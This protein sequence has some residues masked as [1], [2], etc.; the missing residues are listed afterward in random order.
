MGVIVVNIWDASMRKQ[1]Y[2]DFSSARYPVGGHT[3]TERNSIDGL[4]CV[5]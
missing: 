1:V 3:N 4:Y 2:S 5:Q